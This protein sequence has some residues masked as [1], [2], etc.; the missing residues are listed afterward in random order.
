MGPAIFGA[1]TDN[2][3][4]RPRPPY[5]TIVYYVKAKVSGGTATKST[6][7]S[8]ERTFSSLNVGYRDLLRSYSPIVGTPR[9]AGGICVSDS[10]FGVE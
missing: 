4:I 10:R 8:T 9:Q 5:V 2:Y 1:R 6:T 3:N 7:R